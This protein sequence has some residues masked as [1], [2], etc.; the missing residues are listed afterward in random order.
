MHIGTS[1]KNANLNV[2]GNCS[3][4]GNCTFPTITGTTAF[5]DDVHIGEDSNTKQ[6]N[7]N[8]YCKVSQNLDVGMDINVKG[9]LYVSG[10]TKARLVKTKHFGN[11]TMSAYET[12]TPYFGD[13]GSGITDEFCKCYI[14]LDDIFKE[15]II[16]NTEYYVFLQVYGDNKIYVSGKYEDYFIVESNNPNVKFDWEIKCRQ[17]DTDNMR[18]DVIDIE[19]EEDN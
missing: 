1:E 3:V 14:Y 11:V 16:E 5:K 17:K 18:M 6:L 7:V 4:S 2:N 9:N 15:T 13:I 10:G 19:T 12:A 8:G